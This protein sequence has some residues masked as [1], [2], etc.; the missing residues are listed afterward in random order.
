MKRVTVPRGAP[1]LGVA[2]GASEVTAVLRLGGATHT[3]TVPLASPP[4]G[5]AGAAAL[6]VA[7]RTLGERLA[8]GAQRTIDGARVHVALLP[9]LCDAR[10]VPLPP[11]RPA[12]AAAVIRRDAGRHFP[13]NGGR[14]IGVLVGGGGAP[15][16]AAAAPLALV[17]AVAAAARQAGWRLAGVVAGQA[18]WLAAAPRDA[19]V[20]AM[21]EGTAHVLRVSAGQPRALRRLPADDAQAI[22]EAAGDAA[23]TLTFDDA[24][25]GSA[26]HAGAPRR[27][28]AGAAAAAHAAAARLE[29]VP[30]VLAAERRRHQ[31]TLSRRLV[32]AALLLVVTAAGL[33]LW[34]THRRLDA[35]EARRAELRSQVAPLLDARDELDRLD[36]RARA[37]T[38]LAAGSPRWTHALLDIALRLPADAH[39][40]RFTAAGDTVEIEATGA[41]AGAML[42]AVREVP[43][44]RDVRL[45]GAVDRELSDGATASERFR[46]TARYVE[47]SLPERRL[48]P[49]SDDVRLPRAEA[50]EAAG[51]EPATPT[52]TPAARRTNSSREQSRRTGGASRSRALSAGSGGI[53]DGRSTGGES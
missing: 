30:P 36:Q 15:C 28:S 37:V 47:P 5:E 21:V 50:D 9:P 52:A 44:F 40:T 7:F 25:G 20:I 29:L 43:Y 45:R 6:A 16:L 2:V 34:G 39:M 33:E 18:A 4:T 35:V 41:R 12:E 3:A 23:T 17:E 53:A 24:G 46:L 22:A 49:A 51:A 13:G 27:W 31:H 10:L 11:L 1:G 42:Q 48:P 8:A 38:D 19:A 14:I 32:A 26:L